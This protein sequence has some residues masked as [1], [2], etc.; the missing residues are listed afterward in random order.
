MTTK[1]PLKIVEYINEYF[2][3][4]NFINF[5]ISEERGVIYY[6]VHLHDDENR[7]S[8]KFNERGACVGQK[9]EP[10]YSDYREQYF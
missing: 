2:P 7:Y 1:L 3:G 4:K 9:N 5:K 6:V 10:L 8:L